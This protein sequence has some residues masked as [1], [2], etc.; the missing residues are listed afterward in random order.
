MLQA[1]PFFLTL[2]I[3]MDPPTTHISLSTSNFGYIFSSLIYH[4]S[5]RIEHLY[6]FAFPFTLNILYPLK[7]K[8]WIFFWVLSF[9]GSNIWLWMQHSK[10]CFEGYSFFVLPLNLVVLYGILVAVSHGCLFSLRLSHKLVG[11]LMVIVIFPLV[12]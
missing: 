4:A 8:F 1:L 5:S 3:S 7:L 6:L 12:F 11:F 10:L 9:P 2:S